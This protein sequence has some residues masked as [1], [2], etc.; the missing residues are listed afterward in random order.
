MLEIAKQQ[1]GRD[2]LIFRLMAASGFR[3]HEVI[4]SASRQWMDKKWHPQ[5]PTS[6]GLQIQDLRKNGVKIRFK[7]KPSV[8]KPIK[9]EVVRAIR[10]Y[11]G[12]R[13]SGKI[14]DVSISGVEY[15]TRQYARMANPDWIITPR[16]FYDFY[17]CASKLF[18]DVDEFLGLKV[19]SER[20]LRLAEQRKESEVLEYKGNISDANEFCETLVAF[21][22]WKGGDILIGVEDNG[23][24]LGVIDRDLAGIEARITGLTNEYCTPPISYSVERATIKERHVV[25]VR[26]NEGSAKPYWLKNKGPYIRRDDTDRIMTRDEVRAAVRALPKRARRKERQLPL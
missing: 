11:V 16:M 4:G 12:D 10:D 8:F 22:N 24:I 1:S 15:M 25:V 18:S 17:R 5:D 13:T 9:P 6:E 2:F 21:A 26:V 19:T 7:G 3:F 20:V 23:D 14:F